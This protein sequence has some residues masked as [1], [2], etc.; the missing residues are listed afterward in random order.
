MKLQDQFYP[1]VHRPKDVYLDSA[2]SSLTLNTVVTEIE[3]YYQEYRAN[4]HRGLY[5]SS[6]LATQKVEEARQ[7][8]A[9]Y[10][11]SKP[12]EIIFT[13]GTTA[14]LNHLAR[15]LF[16]QN[17]KLNVAI[18]DIEHHANHLPWLRELQKKGRKLHI[19]PTKDGR[20]QSQDLEEFLVSNQID[21]LAFPW[22]SNI[23]GTSQDL[24]AIFK[25]TKKLAVKAIVDACQGIAHYPVS[26][27][28]PADAIVFS[29]HKMYGPT[30]VGV[31]KLSEE[32]SKSLPP[33]FVG[34]GMIDVVD[35]HEVTYAEAPSKFEAGTLPI[36]Q[37]IGLK[38]TI[39]WLQAQDLDDL[40]Q[41]EFKLATQ[42]RDIIE[43]QLP[44]VKFLTTDPESTIVSFW[45][46]DIPVFDMTRVLAEEH[47]AARGGHHCVQPYHRKI[48][49]KGTVRLSFGAYN[50]TEDLQKL[51]H[52]LITIHKIFL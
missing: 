16:D 37:I 50:S 42:A 47:I 45:H 22:V 24:E 6:N 1:L 17:P 43:S 4:T 3:K 9:D 28:A 51:E 41:T 13:A 18:T 35:Y 12:E 36:S 5:E 2:A 10:F 19:I 48:G 39:D 23:F 40:R 31:V 7:A 14:G 33:F 52:A 27:L 20:I 11:S 25:I 44:G 26:V 8:I 49:V 38:K 29:G 15:A 32:L 34:G 30:G 46:P 21:M